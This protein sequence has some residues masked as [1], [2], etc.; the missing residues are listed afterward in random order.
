MSTSVVIVFVF[1][2][3]LK[4]LL[5][6]FCPEKYHSAVDIRHLVVYISNSSLFSTRYEV[7]THSSQHDEEIFIMLTSDIL[8][9]VTLVNFY[10]ALT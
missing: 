5:W 7:Q 6:F 8:T 2:N 3:V 9:K 10:R 4:S 1:D